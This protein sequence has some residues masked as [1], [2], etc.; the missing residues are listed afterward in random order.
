MRILQLSAYL[1]MSLNAFTSAFTY[2]GITEPLGYFDPL[3]FANEKTQSQLNW[4]REAEYKHGRWAMIASLAI[5]AS[6]IVSRKPGIHSLDN[7]SPELIN[8][9]VFVVGLAEL[10]SMINGWKNPIT[11]G[12]FFTMYDHYQ[13]GD[14]ELG[15]PRK[16]GGKD[17]AFIANAEL[18]H[19]RLATI[20]AAGM[21]AQ[22][23]VTNQPL[24]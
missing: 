23:L 15:M 1:Y 10:R 12:E 9:F 6:E 20:G 21:I 3:G 5:P 7:T 17:A 18:N 22:E 11:T 24:F 4:L 16:I 2:L 19:G 14:L 8:A 13:P